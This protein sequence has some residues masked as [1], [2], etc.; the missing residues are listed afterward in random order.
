MTPWPSENDPLWLGRGKPGDVTDASG[1]AD[2]HGLEPILNHMSWPHQVIAK[3]QLT[4]GPDAQ[5]DC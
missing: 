5:R 3:Q 2:G 1:D 4:E